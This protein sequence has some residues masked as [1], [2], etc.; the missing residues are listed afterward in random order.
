MQTVAFHTKESIGTGLDEALEVIGER[1]I[2]G[3]LKVPAFQLAFS[4]LA[5]RQLAP[6]QMPVVQLEHLGGAGRRH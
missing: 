6:Q 2:D 3:D 5:A 4:F 1:E